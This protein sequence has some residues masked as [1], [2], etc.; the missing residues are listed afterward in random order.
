L[1][2]FLERGAFGAKKPAAGTLN[3]F[4]ESTAGFIDT[5][6]QKQGWYRRR[7]WW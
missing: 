6:S 3:S 2:R 5:V 7:L 1:G 4:I